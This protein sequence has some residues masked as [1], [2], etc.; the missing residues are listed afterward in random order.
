MVKHIMS[1]M[2]AC[3]Y[4]YICELQGANINPPQQLGQH[5]DI[6]SVRETVAGLR[7]YPRHI[8]QC[9]T[10]NKIVFIQAEIEWISQ[11]FFLKVS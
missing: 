4:R 8:R 3:L 11:L 7:T 6:Q 9:G 5:A 2:A 10:L 1:I